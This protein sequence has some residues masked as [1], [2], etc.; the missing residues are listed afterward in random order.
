MA[1]VMLIR[2]TKSSSITFGYPGRICGRFTLGVHPPVQNNHF[3]REIQAI[4]KN[5]TLPA[6]LVYHPILDSFHHVSGKKQNT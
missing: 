4:T 1:I 3:E 5:Q 2:T 6:L